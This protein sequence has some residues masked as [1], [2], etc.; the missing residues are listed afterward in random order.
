MLLNA[1]G[2]HSEVIGKERSHNKVIPITQ[3]KNRDD[4]T[5][6][7]QLNAVPVICITFL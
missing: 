6:I 2:L 4:I 5:L 1:D 3:S 7:Y